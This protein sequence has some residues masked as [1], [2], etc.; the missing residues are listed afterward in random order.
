MTNTDPWPPPAGDLL[1][2]GGAARG[3]PAGAG[4]GS[5][6]PVVCGQ[7]CPCVRVAETPSESTYSP[8]KPAT[9]SVKPAVN[10]AAGNSID[11]GIAGPHAARSGARLQRQF[12]CISP[13]FVSGSPFL[14]LRCPGTCGRCV[15][16]GDSHSYFLNGPVQLY[17]VVLVGIW[18]CNQFSRNVAFCSQ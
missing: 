17:C 4:M 7:G 15:A 3:R 5:H 2:A 8:A 10:V 1:A 14:Y 18:G 13:F 16:R 9:L 6:S 12:I 11:G